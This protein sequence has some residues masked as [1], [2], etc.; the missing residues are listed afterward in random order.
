MNGPTVANAKRTCENTK[1]NI[2]PDN[3]E[4]N[5]FK[6][7]EAVQSIHLGFHKTIS[8]TAVHFKVTYSALCDRLKGA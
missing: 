5:K 4:A 6:L 8:S 3:Q 7:K 2:P 1:E